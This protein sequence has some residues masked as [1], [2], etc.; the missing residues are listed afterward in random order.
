[1][2]KRTKTED[3]IWEDLDSWSWLHCKDIEGY[4]EM[5]QLECLSL[6]SRIDQLELALQ[7][8]GLPSV[9]ELDSDAQMWMKQ[10]GFSWN[11]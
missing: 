9:D 6:R 1:M 5:L 4:A 11:D 10:N 8:A 3:E 2:P 7:A